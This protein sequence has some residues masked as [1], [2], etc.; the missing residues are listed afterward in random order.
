MQTCFV[1][2]YIKQQQNHIELYT[3]KLILINWRERVGGLNAE[4]KLL[5]LQ[6]PEIT[7]YILI[8]IKGSGRHLAHLPRGWPW[9]TRSAWYVTDTSIIRARFHYFSRLGHS[10]RSKSWNEKGFVTLSIKVCNHTWKANVRQRR[11][12]WV[13][14][15]SISQTNPMSLVEFTALRMLVCCE[16]ANIPETATTWNNRQLRVG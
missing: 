4:P 7:S 1:T 12:N 6:H 5:Q 11:S 9:G 2:D 8:M 16:T 3:I 13:R 15:S 10:N 14:R